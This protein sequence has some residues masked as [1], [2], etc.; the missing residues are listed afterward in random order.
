MGGT[1]IRTIRTIRVKSGWHVL[2]RS[3]A[4]VLRHVLREGEPLTWDDAR[5]AVFLAASAMVE[6]D[7][8]LGAGRY[9][10]EERIDAKILWPGLKSG[11]HLYGTAL[12]TV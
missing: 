11:W 7:G 9:G 10:A 3:P 8:A 2:R 1:T 12:R 6:V 4:H 5:R